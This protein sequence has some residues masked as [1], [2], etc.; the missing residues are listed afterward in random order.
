MAAGAA[1]T[2]VIAA[3]SAVATVADMAAPPA[4]IAEA[5]TAAAV[6]DTAVAA[7]D[8]GEAKVVEMA[9]TAA[10]E[11]VARANAVRG[12]MKARPAVVS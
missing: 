10:K 7:A 8:M 6:V 11:A 1:D 12:D 9:D 2:V 4:D 5:A 3:A